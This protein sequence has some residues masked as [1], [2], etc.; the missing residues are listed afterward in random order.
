MEGKRTHLTVAF[1]LVQK[2]DLQVLNY[3]IWW[4]FGKIPRLREFGTLPRGILKFCKG[5]LISDLRLAGMYLK[6]PQRRV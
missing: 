3:S 1:L 2:L 5:L 6:Y 4:P